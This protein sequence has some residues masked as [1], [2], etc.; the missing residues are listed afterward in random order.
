MTDITG[1]GAMTLPHGG[2]GTN[3]DYREL[4]ASRKEWAGWK[5]EGTW[6]TTQGR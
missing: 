1:P 3:V 2:T 5:S 6:Q 4:R